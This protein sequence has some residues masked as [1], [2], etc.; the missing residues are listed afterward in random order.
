MIL[1]IGN[2]VGTAFAK[3]M[4]DMTLKILAI[5]AQTNPNIVHNVQDSFKKSMASAIKQ[6]I[7]VQAISAPKLGVTLA[8]AEIDAR[9]ALPRVFWFTWT[10]S[11][12]L[13]YLINTVCIDQSLASET[14]KF[15][16]ESIYEVMQNSED[17]DLLR[18]ALAANPLI[19]EHLPSE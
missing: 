4:P 12:L 6:D 2:M 3:F 17:L 8:L 7:K 9:K 13:D 11:D 10:E 15:Y 19:A 5:S 18:Q 14:T 16:L 1:S